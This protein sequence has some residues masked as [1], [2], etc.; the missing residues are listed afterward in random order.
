MTVLDLCAA[1][2]NKTAQALALGA[3]VVAC[4]RYL[5]R[6]V[7]V[8]P[9]AQRVVLD[10]AMALPFNVKSDRVL[11]DAPCSGTGTLARNPEIKWRLQ[12]DDLAD[13][14]SRQLSIVSAAMMHVAPRG[15][16]V[17]ATCSLEKEEGESVADEALQNTK[18]FHLRNGRDEIA[19]LRTQGLLSTNEYES[20]VDG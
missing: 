18:F 15:K 20:F 6:L 1:P 16:L 9:Q 5:K 4:D 11:V 8:P 3:R 13:L 2:G 12:P 14:R 19:Q 7:D 17:Y 10:A